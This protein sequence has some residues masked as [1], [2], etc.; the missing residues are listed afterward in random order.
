MIFLSNCLQLL[1]MYISHFK[2]L[3]DV[4]LGADKNE[5]AADDHVESSDII[6]VAKESEVIGTDDSSEEKL[7][8][9]TAIRGRRAK[10]EQAKSV[11]DEQKGTDNSEESA[12]SAPVRGRRGKK[13]EATAPPVVQ[14]STRRRNAQSNENSAVVLSVKQ[15]S[16]LSSNVACKP[17]RGRNARKASDDPAEIPEVVAKAEIVPELES[18][19]TPPGNV[20]QEPSENLAALEKPRRGRSTKGLYRTTPENKDV[21]LTPIDN[22]SHVGKGL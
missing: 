2:C 1:W 9:Q 3:P 21:P 17:T 20:S 6:Q 22:A 10:M 8:P 14:K 18:E 7:K 19:Q 15:C 11:E 5:A 4:S 16:T 12:V 13:T